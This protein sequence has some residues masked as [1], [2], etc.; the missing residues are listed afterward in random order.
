MF[1]T[2]FHAGHIYLPTFGV[3]AALGLVLALTLSERT[4]RM[5]GLDPEALWNAGLFAVLAAFLL[6]R[7]LLVTEDFAMF[8][9]YP[10]LLLTVPSLTPVGLALTAGATLGWLRWKGIPMLRAFDAWAPCAALVWAFLAVGHFAEGSDPGMPTAGWIGVRMPGQSVGQYP[11]ALFAAA[12]GL[13][14]T[15]GLVWRLRRGGGATGIALMG[16]GLG[17]FLLCFLREPGVVAVLGLDWLQVMAVGM[18][19]LG[20]SVWVWRADPGLRPGL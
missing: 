17:Q 3:L 9:R 10:V 13:A 7:V 16:V 5:A 6:S 11:V 4:A 12:V 18:M 2:L 8:A 15:F 1:P 20:C 19:V 14:L